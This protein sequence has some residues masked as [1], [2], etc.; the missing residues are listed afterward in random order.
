MEFL[1]GLS[2]KIILDIF[3]AS[4]KDAETQKKKKKSKLIFAQFDSGFGFDQIDC[5]L[6]KIKFF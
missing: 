1:P 2:V 5:Q 6:V 4:K 3:L